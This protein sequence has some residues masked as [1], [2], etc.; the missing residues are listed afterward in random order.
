MVAATIHLLAVAP[1]G[2]ATAADWIT[3]SS[4]GVLMRL[5]MPFLMHGVLKISKEECE[6]GE[7]Q[8]RI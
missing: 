6:Q 1:H 3:A 7:S 5:W 2:V 4:Q 8:G